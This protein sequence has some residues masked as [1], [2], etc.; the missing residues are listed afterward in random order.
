MG[1]ATEHIGLHQNKGEFT[2][3]GMKTPKVRRQDSRPNEDFNTETAQSRL[4]EASDRY[5][6][7][8]GKWG[9]VRAGKLIRKEGIRK[10]PNS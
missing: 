2:G 10:S 5:S 6:M 4:E 8:T 9:L 3:K 7:K 1:K